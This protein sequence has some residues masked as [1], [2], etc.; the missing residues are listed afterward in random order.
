[1]ERRGLKDFSYKGKALLLIL[2]ILVFQLTVSVM[3]R[4]RYFIDED[5]NRKNDYCCVEMTRDAERFFEG[6]GI[7]AYTIVG[8]KYNYSNITDCNHKLRQ[9]TVSGLLPDLDSA[10]M[11]LIL[12]FGWIQVPYESTLL[13]PL[14]PKIY[15]YEDIAISQGFFVNGKQVAN[16]LK[17]ME[18][19]DWIG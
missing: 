13:M 11:W 5:N 6:L 10:H 2:L 9:K 15:G 17:D 19:V 4:S 16:N 12:D 18:W 7:T 3:H 1:M 8:Y 14:D